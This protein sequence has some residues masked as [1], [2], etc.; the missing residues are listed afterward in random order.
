MSLLLTEISGKAFSLVDYGSWKGAVGVQLANKFP[1]STIL[2]VTD[3]AL[4]QQLVAASGSLPNLVITN[5]SINNDLLTKL[6]HCPDFF[7]YQF[8]GVSLFQSFKAWF[9]RI[10][11]FNGIYNIR[12]SC[13]L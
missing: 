11:R 10:T 5:A 8:L 3:G 13:L 6:F 12:V 1:N 4:P 2:S 9:F 7:R